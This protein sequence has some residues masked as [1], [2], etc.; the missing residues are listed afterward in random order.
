MDNLLDRVIGQ[1][2]TLI[3][4]LAISYEDVFNLIK[5][6][7]NIWF[8]DYQE[9][10]LPNSYDIY[11]IQ[12]THA[13][14]L[15]GYSYFEAF[16]ADLVR[17]I[18]LS[19]PVMLP[20]KKQLKYGEILKATDYATILDLMIDMEIRDLFHGKM[21]VVVEYFKKP[22]NLEWPDNLKCEFIVS[23]CTRNC[24]VHN[25]SKADYRLAEVSDYKVGDKIK[26]SSSDVHSYGLRVRELVRSL[27]RQANDK[28]FERSLKDKGGVRA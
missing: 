18:Y 28:Y 13:G 22:L 4:F 1:L 21:D 20:K 11:R 2:D 8:A 24:I 6:E 10:A 12:I 5:K 14:F 19:M 17:Q 9:S 27:Y 25:L 26:L 7:K 16:L 23:S 15:L 3:P